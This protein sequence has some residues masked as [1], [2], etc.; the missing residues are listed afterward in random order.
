MKK[1]VILHGTAG[2][3]K[4]NWFSWLEQQ[5]KKEN[6]KVWVPQLPKAKRPNIERYNK[7]IFLNKPWDFN[8]NSILIGHSSGAVAILGLLQNLPGKTPVDSCYLI[9]SFHN[10]LGVEDLSELFTAPFN[11]EKIK[12]KAKHFV[13]I[14]SNDDPYCPLE[15]AEYLAGKLEAKLIILKNEKHFSISSAGKKYK[16]FTFLFKL[17]KKNHL[18]KIKLKC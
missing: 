7:Y 4:D 16:K 13:F 2:T 8:R 17:I 6:C 9:G 12:K 18:A 11:F 5:L 1:F 14:H 10:N 3:P 15:H